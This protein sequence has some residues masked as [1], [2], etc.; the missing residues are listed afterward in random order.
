MQYNSGSCTSGTSL[1]FDYNGVGDSLGSSY[2]CTRAFY[3]GDHVNSSN[4][5]ATSWTY[6]SRY[7]R[8][9]TGATAARTQVMVCIDVPWQ[10]DYCSGRTPSGVDTW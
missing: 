7:Q 6:R 9:D 3:D 2:S 1:S 8:A 4:V 10:L 5:T